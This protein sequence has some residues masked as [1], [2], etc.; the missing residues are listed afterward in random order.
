M[1]Y[2]RPNWDDY[3]MAIARIIATRSTC[4]RLRAG[5][6][7]VKNNRIIST[8]YNGSPPGLP[9]CDSHAGHLMEEG[10]CVRTVHAEHNAILQAAMAPGQSTENSIAYLVYSPC[11]HCSK[12]LVS[13]GVK[14][15][16]IGNFYRNTK[17][18]DYLKQAGVEVE[19][20]KPNTKWNEAVRELFKED[21]EEVKAREG[22]VKM[23]DDAGS[24]ESRPEEVQ[25]F[26]EDTPAKPNQFKQ[27][28]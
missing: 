28:Y 2:I 18:I 12:Y 1:K 7:L 5:A 4:D 11:I 9:H 27:I 20:Y 22:Y 15:V 19:I 21:I 25:E 24:H 3:F 6:V 16:V 14:R 13:A 26:M 8:G 23:K 10:H 17:V